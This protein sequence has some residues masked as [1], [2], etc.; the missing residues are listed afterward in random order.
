MPLC[1][2]EA[3]AWQKRNSLPLVTRAERAAAVAH[4]RVVCARLNRYSLALLSLLNLSGCHF[5]TLAYRLPSWRV[6]QCASLPATYALPADGGFRS[7]GTSG[8]A[9]LAIS[10]TSHLPFNRYT[11][12]INYNRSGIECRIF[13]IFIR[14]GN[15]R[16]T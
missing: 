9:R 16:I 14:N 3:R 13:K 11:C 5:P 1:H 10:H 2:C 15:V 7:S 8:I 6:C 4:V 12:L